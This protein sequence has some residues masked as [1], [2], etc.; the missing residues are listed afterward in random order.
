MDDSLSRRERE[1]IFRESEIIRTAEFLFSKKGYENCSM[2]E[3]A[4]NSEFTKK[5]LYR[6]FI[7]KQ[8]LFF[9]VVQKCYEKLNSYLE[10]SITSGT[11]GYEKVKSGLLAYYKF[12]IDNPDKFSLMNYVGFVKTDDIDSPHYKKFLEF[13]D[14]LFK[15]IMKLVDE[16]KE[17]KSIRTDLETVNFTYSIIFL[18]TGFF[19]ELSIA[20]RTFTKHFSLNEEIFCLFVID[21]LALTFNK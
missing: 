6:Y 4:K 10:S 18:I 5:T 2:D 19:H 21:L 8:D 1:K 3:I 7:N 14:F 20:G 15:K 13:D 9:A 11:N 17:D 16:G 12:Y